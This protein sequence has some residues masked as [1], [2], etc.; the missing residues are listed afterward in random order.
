MISK[1]ITI[2][3]ENFKAFESMETF[4]IAPLTLLVGPNN[5]GKS[6][7][8]KI[9]ELLNK[10]FSSR[11]NHIS[12]LSEIKF[13]SAPW[14]SSFDGTLNKY[15]Y[16]SLIKIKL[17]NLS[18]KSSMSE[19]ERKASQNELEEIESSGLNFDNIGLE[20]NFNKNGHDGLIDSLYL[21]LGDRN[22]SIFCGER[23]NGSFIEK[24]DVDHLFPSVEAVRNSSIFKKSMNE[25]TLLCDSNNFTEEETKNVAWYTLENIKKLRRIDL[26]AFV[27]GQNLKVGFK[28]SLRNLANLIN[29]TMYS[30]KG[31]APTDQGMQHMREMEE[32]DRLY[33][34]REKKKAVETSNYIF[35]NYLDKII[36]YSILPYNHFFDSFMQIEK[37]NPTKNWMLEQ[38]SSH[39]FLSND[40]KNFIN[41]WLQKFGLG[42]SLEIRQPEDDLQLIYIVKNGT[43]FRLKD[44]GDGAQKIV[45]LL[46]GMITH[47]S[48]DLLTDRESQV[49]PSKFFM[50]HEP[51]ESLHPRL[52]SLLG[53]LLVN[54]RQQF[55][56]KFIVETHSE[57]LIRKLQLLTSEN[58]VDCGDLVVNY[59]HENDG[60]VKSGEK[61]YPIHFYPDGR[62]NQEFGS[63]FYD[64]NTQTLKKH[65]FNIKNN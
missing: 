61:V 5:S 59:L 23:E 27:G 8:I 3:L 53:D 64:E 28:A 34:P 62:L 2:G 26:S 13:A 14:F 36:E 38:P 40:K 35:D 19:G 52:Q 24:L 39:I 12:S 30:A 11:S 18:L 48:K 37:I 22:T 7:F 51:E 41:N 47:G 21:Y 10:N 33:V 65:F 17:N 4:E 56:V 55:G 9:L 31:F 20:V 57:Y 15:S 58:K 32:Y 54:I 63:G 46:L 43:L 44:L 60:D 25:K 29:D 6:S 50:I 45:N 49:K 1:N 16:N 42:D